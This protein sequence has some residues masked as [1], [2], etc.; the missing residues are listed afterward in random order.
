MSGQS[1]FVPLRPLDRLSLYAMYSLARFTISVRKKAGDGRLKGICMRTWFLLLCVWSFLRKLKHPSSPLPFEF[2]NII[3]NLYNWMH[4]KQ[5]E[6]TVWV[7][8]TLSEWIRNHRE[9]CHRASKWFQYDKCLLP[10]LVAAL[11]LDPIGV[12]CSRMNSAVH[13]H[14]NLTQKNQNFTSIMLF[15]LNCGMKLLFRPVLVTHK[16]ISWRM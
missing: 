5:K 14:R 13:R 12:Q 2:I 16:K 10:F 3:R 8:T 7:F 6:S 4:Y 9:G 11:H 15:L 1:V